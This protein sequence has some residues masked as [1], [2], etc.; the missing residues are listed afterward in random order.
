MSEEP[1]PD[2]TH[3][4][5]ASE[6]TE[7]ASA[8]VSETSDVPLSPHEDGPDT[9]VDEA[10]PESLAQEEPL[11]AEDVKEDQRTVKEGQEEVTEEVPK[12]EA[13]DP[14]EAA[15]SDIEESADV[16]SEVDEEEAKLPE[17]DELAETQKDEVPSDD[18]YEPVPLYYEDGD[19][20]AGDGESNATSNVETTGSAASATTV[21][22]EGKDLMQYVLSLPFVKDPLFLALDDETKKNLISEYLQNPKDEKFLKYTNL[23]KS[24]A[25]SFT[26]DVQD[27]KSINPF[28][29][30]PDLNSPMTPEETISYNAFMAQEGEYV[31]SGNWDQFPVGSRLFIGNLPANTVTKQTL[32]RIFSKYGEV[33]Q[34]SIKAGYGFC[35]FK[36]V[37]QCMDSIQGER[38]V[39]LH[40]K[41]MHLEVSKSQQKNRNSGQYISGGT[42]RGR[43]NQ[44]NI[45]NLQNTGG[46]YEYTPISGTRRNNSKREYNDPVM[47][48]KRQKSESSFYSQGSE[49]NIPQGT[50]CQLYIKKAADNGLVN[51]LMLRLRNSGIVVNVMHLAPQTSLRALINDAA[52]T[53]VNGVIVIH[54]DGNLD[55]QIFQTSNDGGVRFDEYQTVTIEVAVELFMRAKGTKHQNRGHDNH[56]GRNNSHRRNQSRNHGSSFDD[57]NYDNYQGN[58]SYMQPQSFNGSQQS[59][60]SFQQQPYQQNSYQQNSYQQSSYRPPRQQPQQQ[61]QQLQQQPPVQAPQISPNVLQTLSSFDQNSLQS[62]FSLV[63]QVQPGNNISTP[64][65]PQNPYGYPPQQQ[66]A[67]PAY[68]PPPQQYNQPPPPP[69]PQQY[70]PAEQA[71]PQSNNADPNNIQSLMQTL[72]RLQQN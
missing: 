61:P 43:Q 9:S 17:S 38:Q 30:R 64:P 10:S 54:R 36:T 71:P 41:V 27:V 66:P 4:E 72:Q 69:P 55:V 22:T 40:G 7:P 11:Q 2:A 53:G 67:Q 60:G 19:E 49:N 24:N 42:A 59:Q 52:H 48:A 35:Q 13:E 37:D 70:P 8:P 34:I 15:T 16:V 6:A 62:L 5:P 14:K 58:Q 12:K 21:G 31:T 56:R 3:L 20:K 63:Q 47:D 57:D 65:P 28:C 33:I 51:Q 44:S 50:E 26:E 46:T 1:I 18:E 29:R 23:A 68:Q 25:G 32:W 45:N 39:P